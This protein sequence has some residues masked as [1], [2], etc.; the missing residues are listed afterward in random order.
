[1]QFEYSLLLNRSASQCLKPLCPAAVA[2]TAAESWPA[3]NAA[4]GEPCTPSACC[5]AAQLR[6]PVDGFGPRTEVM[7]SAADVAAGIVRAKQAV[8]SAKVRTS[9]KGPTQKA[10]EG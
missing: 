9:M 4:D 2:A 6:R 5:C 10:L 3:V 7:E 1:M 8:A